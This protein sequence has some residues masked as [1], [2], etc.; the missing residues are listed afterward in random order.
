[1]GKPGN[2]LSPTRVSVAFVAAAL[3]L[4]GRDQPDHALRAA[5][6]ALALQGRFAD[7][8]NEH[9]DWPRM[10]VGVNSGEAVVREVGGAGHVAYPVLGDPVNTGARLETLAPPGGV[11]IGAETYEQLPDGAVVEER[12]GLRVKGKEQ[13]VNA[14]VL[15]ALPT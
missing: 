3:P 10:R 8:A 9:P 15:L 13:A 7:L 11:L 14:Y 2:E 6:A 5:R 1:M 4:V 12:S